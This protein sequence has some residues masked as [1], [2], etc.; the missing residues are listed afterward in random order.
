MVTKELATLVGYKN[1]YGLAGW[2]TQIFAF[3][4]N[5][6]V[7]E[8]NPGNGSYQL[9]AATSHKWYGAGVYTVLPN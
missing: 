6:E 1:I 8:V 2:R 5:G 3:N 7:I 9:I 4:A